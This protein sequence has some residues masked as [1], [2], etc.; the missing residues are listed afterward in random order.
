[1]GSLKDLL[2]EAKRRTILVAV[3]VLI[4]AYIMS[5][6]LAFHINLKIHDDAN[7]Y[8]L[9]SLCTNVSY[10]RKNLYLKSLSS[11]FLSGHEAD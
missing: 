7:F 3:L 4:G 10:Y 2:E 8:A 11:Y 6:T 9:R 5:C 1:M